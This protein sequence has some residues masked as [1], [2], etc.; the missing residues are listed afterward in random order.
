MSAY[1]ASYMAE[2]CSQW[3][4]DK[5]PDAA[6]RTYN[7]C[8]LLTRQKG[9]QEPELHEAIETYK[10]YGLNTGEEDTERRIERFKETLATIKATYQPQKH[11]HRY[12]GY[13]SVKEQLL[14]ALSERT[15]NLDLT[16]KVWRGKYK[17]LTLD[18][19]AWAYWAMKIEQG[20]AESVEFGYAYLIQAFKGNGRRCNRWQ[21]RVL[22]AV[23]QAMG[24]IELV[25]GYRF[26]ERTANRWHVVDLLEKEEKNCSVKVA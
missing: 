8:A 26:A 21:A 7:L 16:Y 24:A 14:Q 19:L 15:K 1:S 20:G 18:E 25:E 5:C 11:G 4:P 10:R 6:K 2:Q 3:T 13:E 12:A 17:T 9:G 23:L 22:F